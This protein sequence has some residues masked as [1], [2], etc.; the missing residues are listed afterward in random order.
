MEATL[1]RSEILACN[2]ALAVNAMHFGLVP[3]FFRRVDMVLGLVEM[4]K[5]LS[6]A[7]GSAQRLRDG[8]KYARHCS[9]P[10]R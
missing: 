3:A 8:R 7:A 2:E 4:L 6:R 9:D 10:P 5:C 1:S